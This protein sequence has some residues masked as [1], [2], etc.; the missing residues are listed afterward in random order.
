M[1]DMYA[2]ADLNEE[3]EMRPLE[4]ALEPPAIPGPYSSAIQN[5]FS[6][7][8]AEIRTQSETVTGPIQNISR[9]RLKDL[10]TI[11]NNELFKFFQKPDRTPHPNGIAEAIFRRYGHDIPSLNR[12]ITPISKDLN[13]DASMNHIIQDIDT[14]L[15][16]H[17]GT[18][19]IS[20]V[21]QLKW[22]FNQY[23]TIGEEILRLESILSQKTEMLDKL[24]QRMP[25]ITSLSNNDALPG[26]LESF[27]KYLE[28]SFQDS[29]FE[30]TYVKLAELYK[31]WSILRE[32]IS[33]QQ[34][35]SQSDQNE[36]LCSICIQDSI[37]HAIIPCG[38][39]F[40]TTCARKINLTC[41]IC[42][43]TI[44]EKIKLYL[45]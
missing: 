20:L 9:K 42:R 13:V 2:S 45:N 8:C 19:S 44:R 15:Q 21:Q 40:C 16:R 29:K 3:D 24:Q 14:Q 10:V 22:V 30:D 26:L 23:R 36:P 6:R 18:T 4:F 38:H 27:S 28:K 25:M 39:T 17:G 31:K 1:A 41:Y 35:I 32:I 12:N 33:I 34:S 43:G 37:T 7:H 11:Q 5:I